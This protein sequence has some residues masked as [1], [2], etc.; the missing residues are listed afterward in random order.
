M[1]RGPSSRA[2][3]LNRSITCA[4]V[5]DGKFLRTMAAMPA[6]SGDENEVPAPHAYQSCST[7]GAGFGSGIGPQSAQPGATTS[8]Q[9]PQVL[10]SVSPPALSVAPT[11]STSGK[12]AGYCGCPR[13]V[14]P[15][16]ATTRT[17]AAVALMI[18]SC[19]TSSA[20]ASPPR[21]RLMILAPWSAAHL[22]PA[23]MSASA[24]TG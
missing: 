15:A 17:P 20:G 24:A 18:A 5:S 10:K 3:V 23:A 9:S 21:E 7:G 22:M 2:V 12:A 6:T 4:G 19:N 14:L 1:P 11:A 13:P 16:A 8:T